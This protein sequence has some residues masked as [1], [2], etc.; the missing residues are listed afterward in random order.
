MSTRRFNPDIYRDFSYLQRIVLDTL[1][2]MISTTKGSMLTF[3]AKK[4]ASEAGLPTHPVV[5]TLIKEVIEQ[6]REQGLVRRLSRTAHGVKYAVNKESPLWI[7]AKH[8]E[9][10]GELEAV[11]A[12]IRLLT[13]AERGK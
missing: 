5:L 10:N 7:L 8:G 4:I 13:Y 1:G 3:N 12:R 11:I 6:L 9:L 2:K